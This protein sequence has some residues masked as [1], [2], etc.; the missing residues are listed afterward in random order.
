[1]SKLRKTVAFHKYIFDSRKGRVDMW[2]IVVQFLAVH[3]FCCA[4]ISSSF[5]FAQFGMVMT[6]I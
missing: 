3:A 6:L 2:F 5:Q 4:V 1:M